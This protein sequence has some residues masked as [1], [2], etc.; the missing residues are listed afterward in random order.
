MA[1]VVV[2]VHVNGDASQTSDET[3]G[4]QADW[5]RS[6]VKPRASMSVTETLNT[7]IVTTSTPHHYTRF[8]TFVRA[9]FQDMRP[10]VTPVKIPKDGLVTMAYTYGQTICTPTLAA[11]ATQSYESMVCSVRE[12]MKASLRFYGNISCKRAMLWE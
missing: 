8:V 2:A 9:S 1:C 10:A 7:S 11:A 6:S 4:A 12:H 3:P 5:S